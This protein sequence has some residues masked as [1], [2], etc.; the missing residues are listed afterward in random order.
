MNNVLF[1]LLCLLIFL[2]P[3]PFGGNEEWAIYGFELLVFSGG[4]AYFLGCPGSGKVR[5][6]ADKLRLPRPVLFFFLLFFIFCLLQIIPLPGSWVG[7]ISPAAYEWRKGLVE[8]NLMP[9]SSLRWQTISLS[10][11]N[12]AYELLKFAAY[13]LFA[14]LLSRTLD[15]KFK[16]RALTAVL[17]SSGLFQALYGMSEHFGGTHRIFTWVNRYYSGSAFGTFVNRDHYAALL[18][19]VFP[20]SVGYFLVRADY[21]SIRRGLNWRQRLVAFG[22]DRLQKSLLFIIPPIIIGVGLV[23]SRCRSGII[24]FL[25]SFSLM[26]LVLSL[27]RI[28]G[29]R[30]ME[31]KLVRV[32]FSLVIMAAILIGLN[33]VLER[34][35]RE[36]LFDQNRLLFYRST[37]NLIRDFPL[38]GAGLGTYVKAIN[39]YL[40]KNFGVIVSHAHNDYLEMLAEAG[41]IAGG[42]LVLAGFWLLG[43]LFH[44]WSSVRSPLG[45]GIGLGALIGV[46]AIFLHSLTDFS[47]R[48][49]GNAVTWVSLFVLASRC[50]AL[51]SGED[52]QEAEENLLPESQK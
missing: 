46:L 7:A 16:V 22:Q 1:L 12:S 15:S 30:R 19:M 49:P 17:I 44:R 21:F 40:R 18:E 28:S 3:L 20:L 43:F 31:K 8:L 24:I 42:L 27:S 52:G 45:R 6:Q 38:T 41:M 13:A 33:P 23:F 47:L 4:L 48:M 2:L 50:L 37:I 26:L 51:T 29:R 5:N 10:P 35:T 25:I 32:V 36:G 39:P 34:F 9:A 11:W 14:F